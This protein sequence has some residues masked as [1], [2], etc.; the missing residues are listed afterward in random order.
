MR[1]RRIPWTILCTVLA[2]VA[3]GC[4]EMRDYSRYPIGFQTLRRDAPLDDDTAEWHEPYACEKERRPA[5]DPGPAA[6][7][8][9]CGGERP[10]ARIVPLTLAEFYGAVGCSDLA[11]SA[12]LRR[13]LKT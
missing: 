13:H 4:A 1:G 8:G 2:V 9:E 11:R 7:L 5:E 12:R 3:G 6:N 10:S